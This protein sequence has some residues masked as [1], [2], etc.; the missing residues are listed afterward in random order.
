VAAKP[1]EGF[2]TP[3]IARTRE[4]YAA[5]R[6]YLPKADTPRLF[7]FVEEALIP[8]TRRPIGT[9]FVTP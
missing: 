1:T 3:A 9:G 4:Q 7:S 2:V 5:G 6:G 8:H